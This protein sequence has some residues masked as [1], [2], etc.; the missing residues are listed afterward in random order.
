MTRIDQRTTGLI[1]RTRPLTDT[2]LI[3]HWLTPDFGRLAT[4]A[5]G[6]RRPKSPFAGKLDLFFLADFSFRL[7]RRSDLHLLCE[8]TVRETY[9]FLRRE[10]AYLQQAAYC[11]ALI[12]QTTEPQTPL[13]ALFT[14]LNDFLDFLPTLAPQS[15]PV[16]AFEMKF[17]A[18]SGLQPNLR[19]ASLGDDARQVLDTI[20]R[21][22]WP[23]LRDVNLNSDEFSEINGFLR[24]FLAS[25]LDRIPSGRE[26]AVGG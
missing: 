3:V 5:K 8:A 7:S 23:R 1:V 16:F 12:E 6:A 9:S 21:A 11:A 26:A 17:L 19:E 25:N 22:D 2:S 4:V 18:E 14:L 13:P 15:L 20:S 24:D 10:L